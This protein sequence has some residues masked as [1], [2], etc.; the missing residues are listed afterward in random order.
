MKIYEQAK[1]AH[2]LTILCYQPDYSQNSDDPVA[3]TLRSA[4]R[5]L[6]QVVAINKARKVRLTEI[7]H[8]RIAYQEYVD[9]RDA[10]D[11]NISATYTKLQKKDGPKINKKKKKGEVNNSV[12]GIGI[13]GAVVPL[14]NPASLGLGPDDDNHLV[15]PDGLHTLVE[16]R[17]Q[18]VDVIGGGFE[19]MERENPGRIRGLPQKSVFEGIEE[20]VQQELGV[21]HYFLHWGGS[22]GERV[23]GHSAPASVSGT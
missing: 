6:K 8:D 18:W 4:Q 22:R 11:K 23:D 21:G 20:E 9:A 3:A 19:V 16:M 10:I 17:R 7:A 15:V 14:P 5:Q 2:S 1:F 13:N 12:N